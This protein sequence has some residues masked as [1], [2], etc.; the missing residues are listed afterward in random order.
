MSYYFNKTSL[1][2]DTDPQGLISLF[3]DAP[4]GDGTELPT[5]FATVT[6]VKK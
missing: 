5:A 6:F 2:S 4:L 1:D 3:V